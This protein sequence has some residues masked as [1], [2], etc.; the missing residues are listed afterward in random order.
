[1]SLA[2]LMSGIFGALPC[3]GVLIRTGVNIANGATNKIS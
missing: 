3:T 2:N 1:M